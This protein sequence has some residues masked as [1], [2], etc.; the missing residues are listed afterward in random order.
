LEN[1]EKLLELPIIKLIEMAKKH[2]GYKKIEISE[3]QQIK[4]LRR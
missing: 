4:M 2:V 3:E 1:K